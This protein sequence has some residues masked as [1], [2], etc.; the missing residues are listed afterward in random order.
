MCMFS[1]QVNK[2]KCD[3]AMLRW[4]RPWFVWQVCGQRDRFKNRL[5]SVE[6]EKNKVQVELKQSQDAAHKLR[7]DNVKLY[8]RIRFLQVTRLLPC[9]KIACDCTERC[10]F[11][12]FPS[13]SQSLHLFPLVLSLPPSLARTCA[14]GYKGV[15]EKASQGTEIESQYKQIYEET[16]NPF[17]E[18]QKRLE[19]NRMKELPLRDRITLSYGKFFLSN[20]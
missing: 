16:N 1:P 6:E 9:P 2:P 19:N 4:R 11:F 15:S 3:A 10:A 14:Q 5:E 7:A 17:N 12:F 20:K 18:F 13:L 8:E